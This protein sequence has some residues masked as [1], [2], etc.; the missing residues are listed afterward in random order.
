MHRFRNFLERG[1]SNRAYSSIAL[2]ALI[3]FPLVRL[4]PL[5]GEA[6]G[7]FFIGAWAVCGY[8]LEKL[9]GGK[10]SDKPK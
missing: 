10:P 6:P 4:I 8:I 1:E 3:T 5:S 9:Y 2:A 7:W